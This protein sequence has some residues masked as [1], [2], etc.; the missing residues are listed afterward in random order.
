MAHHCSLSLSH[1]H[2][3]SFSLSPL[4]HP[5]PPLASLIPLSAHA[6]ETTRQTAPH[7]RSK[8]VA[9]SRSDSAFDPRT[10]H[11]T[12]LSQLSSL[13]MHSWLVWS[14]TFCS[15]PSTHRQRVS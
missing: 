14:P 10:L 11:P 15:Q 1:T 7:T 3:L 12:H 5:H 6:P 13:D 9:S 8:H 2:T 4:S